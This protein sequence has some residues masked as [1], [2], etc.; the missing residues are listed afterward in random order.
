MGD[1][2]LHRDA[3]LAGVDVPAGRDRAGGEFDV[4]VGST[5]TGHDER[6]QDSFLIPVI[7]VMR[8]PVAVD[9]VKETLRTRGSLISASPRLPPGPVRTDS[10]PSGSPASVKQRARASAVS[11]VAGWLSTTALPAVSAGA[12]LRT[13]SR[14]G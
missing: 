13:T 6:V 14:A 12:S 5:T 11:G 3:D 7:C 8:R 10:T 9:P 4:R 1:D 2:P